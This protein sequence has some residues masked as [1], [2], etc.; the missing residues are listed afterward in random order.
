MKLSL[1]MLALVLLLGCGGRV[2]APATRPDAG[3]VKIGFVYNTGA[4]LVNFDREQSVRLAAQEINSAGGINGQPLQIL[5]SGDQVGSVT[6]MQG[7]QNL[8]DQGVVALVGGAT[9]ALTLE[10]VKLTVP[11]GIPIIAPSSTSPS[12]SQLV[13]NGVKVSGDLT[14]RTAP[15]DAFQG[16]ILANQ[17]KSLGIL[18]VAVIYRNDAYGAGLSATFRSRF[19]AIGG[20]VRTLV[21]YA[22]SK[23]SNF[24]AEVAQLLAQ[25]TP[26]G[27]VMISLTADGA[28]LTRDLQIANIQP[29][30]TFFS[31]D[32][33]FNADFLNNGAPDLIEGMY[34]TAPAAP[35]GFANY[36]TYQEAF[37]AR[38][39]YS[40]VGTTPAAS[41]DAVYLFALAMAAGGQNTPAAIRQNLR[42]VSG[43]LQ[44]GG[45][46]VNPG[47]FARA[48]NLLKAGR[49]IN[50]DGAT[51]RIDFD[52]NG[53]VTSGSYLW[54]RIQNRAYK[55]L[56]VINFP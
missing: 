26:M 6:G 23:T 14:W 13:V 54:W 29:R 42:A 28:A 52:A 34:G 10:T 22:S 3:S 38:M 36:L 25:G 17:V 33:V 9:S 30:P 11:L 12:L 50:F 53:D 15:S 27:L 20:T 35:E 45:S 16:V 51:G 39:G 40:P 24:S 19:E 8:L 37:R 49:K 1:P 21:P 32:A 55:S 18:D 2:D 5:V 43:G 7:T 31:A 46:V 48:V 4:G 56:E 47:E 41:Y 44:D